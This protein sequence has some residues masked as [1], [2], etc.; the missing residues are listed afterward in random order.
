MDSITGDIF[1]EIRLGYWHDGENPAV[2]VSGGSVSGNMADNLGCMYMS[3][4]SR[5]FSDALIPAVTR[6]ENIT[7]SGVE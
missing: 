4:E 2:P 5:R 3:R 6:L 1:G 7:V